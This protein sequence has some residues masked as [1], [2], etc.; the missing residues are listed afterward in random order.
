[1]GFF[2]PLKAAYSQEVDN[3]L[4]TYPG[5]AVSLRHVAGLFRTAYAKTATI[6]KAEHAFA[7]TGIYPYRPNIISD[8]HFEP[9]EVTHKDK[10][11]DENLELTED[12][13]TNVDS[14]L[15]V[16]GPDLPTSASQRT[17]DNILPESTTHTSIEAINPLPKDS[18][19]GKQR[20]R[21]S[22]KSEILSGPPYKRFI[23][24]KEKDK[25]RNMK[26]KV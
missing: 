25:A 12:R 18:V 24:S 23:E 14:P 26:G 5:K 20:K 19:E 3:W 4:V 8:E 9:S 7:A 11:P 21:K 16:D 22:H 15:R 1:V 17:P 6:E 2:G 10:T 13:H